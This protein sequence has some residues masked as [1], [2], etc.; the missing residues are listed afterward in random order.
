MAL[1]RGVF[2]S[3]DGGGDVP[4]TTQ[5]MNDLRIDPCIFHV[6]V[7]KKFSGFRKDTRNFT[8]T[9]RRPTAFWQ[10]EPIYQNMASAVGSL[11]GF[12]SGEF[13]EKKKVKDPQKRSPEQNSNPE[14]NT[15]FALGIT[16]IDIYLGGGFKNLL[17]SS[18]PGEMIQFD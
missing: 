2:P 13:P 10:V 12:G 14:N 9:S 5:K 8:E 11:S 3:V 4:Q 7:N 1:R 17:F 15:F 16:Y 18:L 6:F